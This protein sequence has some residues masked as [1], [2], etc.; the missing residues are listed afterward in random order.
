MRIA[1][2]APPDEAVPPPGYGGTERVVHYLAE[3]LVA[4]GHDVLLVA[5]AG[6]RTAGTLLPVL[7]QPL[8]SYAP[9]AGDIPGKPDLAA[10]VAGLLRSARVDV[11]HN[12]FRHLLDVA[13]DIRQPMLTTIH[14]GLDQAPQNATFLD[15]PTA[16]YVAVSRSQAAAAPDLNV[17]A[18][19]YHGIPVRQFPFADVPGDYLA[20]VGRIAPEKGLDVAIR[21]ARQARLPLAIAARLMPQHQAYFSR[22]IVPHL[23]HG[24]TSFLGELGQPAKLGLLCGARAL[25]AP[26]R[27]SEPFG[28]VLIEAL[29]CGTPVIGFPCGAVPEIVADGEVGILVG[30]ET[31]MVAAV[32]SA[33]RISRRGCR[34]HVR[35]RFSARVMTR[36][37]VRAYRLVAGC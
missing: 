22:E 10:S 31:E 28:L 7:P 37:Y 20:F 6:S 11:V 32:R 12:H 3:Q 16:K 35:Y 13:E 14:Y 25:L 24:D 17:V 33:H 8:S 4:D 36:R 9:D 18:Q 15:H 1:L 21:V 26:V 27:W 19:I 34:S 30:D 29:A 5:A 2:V 23:G